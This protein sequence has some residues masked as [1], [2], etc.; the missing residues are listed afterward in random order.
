M[1][2]ENGD[3]AFLPLGGTG[4]IG[5]NLNLYRCDGKWLAID[6]GIGF[7]GSEHPEVD[8]MVPDPAY[9]A[10]R[11]DKL[12]GLVITHAHED[13]VGAVAHLWPQLRCP[14]Y[15][16]PFA[17]AVLRR[18]LIEAQ[19]LNQVKIH[20]VP[21]G[22]SIDLAPFKLRFIR[23][24]HSIPE[25][26]A[27]AIETPHGIVLHTGDWKMDPTPLV[28]PPTDEAALAALGERGVLAMVCDSTNA[29]VEGHSGSEAEVRQS[30]SVLLR[31]LR[32]RVAVTCF[33]SNVAR[34]ESIVH[35]AQA[36]GRSVAM[37]GRS[38]R[39][40]DAAARECG[41][42]KGIPPFLS[43][44][45]IDDVPD[46][47]ILIL[48][49]G[50]QG[51]PRS[52][53]ARVAMDSHR[54]VALGE[55]DTVIF[56]SRVIPGNERAIGTVQD[57]LVRRGVHLMTDADHMIHVSGHP[58]RDELRRLYRLVKPRYSV[59]VHGEWRHLSAH[60]ALAQEAGA[61]PILIEDGDILQLSANRTEVID[62]AP[63]G[64]LVPDGGRLVPLSGGVMAA[65]R[66]MLFNGVVLASIAVD[67]AGRLRGQPRVSA[68]GLL[69]PDSPETAQVSG[70][71]AEAV[72]DLP[73]ALRRDD[74]ALTDAARAALRRAL[75][76]RLQKRPLVDVHLLRV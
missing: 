44:D 39:N 45:D 11:R 72:A 66:R 37:V 54:H 56:S 26:Q 31:G 63:V 17:A 47:N 73:I 61:T 40:L 62:S 35:A 42:L 53:L 19:L 75:G 14:V 3:L 60:A 4:E 43:E 41:Y 24:A 8:I 13:H 10:E 22:G 50:S 30:L 2:I 51:E 69:D 25:S 18:K 29:M 34:V 27:L 9:I 55:G 49:T 46:D 36:V 58:A 32:G 5:M 70:E 59:P 52:A 7:G 28:G 48:I 38:L 76:K 6:C 15:A 33:A 67:E 71:L 68:P 12:L 65:R 21:P 23:M 20:I 64:R 1:D 74:A 57:N 16:T